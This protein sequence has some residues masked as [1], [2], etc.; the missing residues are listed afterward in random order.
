[1]SIDIFLFFSGFQP[2]SQPPSTSL[3]FHLGSCAI[4]IL[5][6]DNSIREPTDRPTTWL[7][8]DEGRTTPTRK[9]K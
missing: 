7:D 5:R 3:F 1:L 2:A 8:G 9:T 6:D 4:T